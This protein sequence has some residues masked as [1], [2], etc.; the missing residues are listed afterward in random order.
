MK[1]T[2]IY[3]TPSHVYHQGSASKGKPNKTAAACPKGGRKEAT[4]ASPKGK[5]MT[6]A[7]YVQT[8]FGGDDAKAGALKRA[9]GVLATVRPER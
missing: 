7:Q 4:T 5:R 6:P 1:S 9:L 2:R 8:M 3:P